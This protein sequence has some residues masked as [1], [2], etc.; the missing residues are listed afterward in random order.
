[1]SGF[2]PK[3]HFSKKILIIFVRIFV[4]ALLKASSLSW[5]FEALV[6][7]LKV[8]GDH[9]LVPGTF[10]FS[11]MVFVVDEET[12]GMKSRSLRTELRN[13]EIKDV[14]VPK[15]FLNLTFQFQ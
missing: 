1:M 6:P 14:I 7:V 9:V 4:Y 10:L 3:C 12:S 2:F 13:L 8:V 15:Q 5:I 11:F